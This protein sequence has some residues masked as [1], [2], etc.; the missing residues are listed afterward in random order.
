MH[1][2][3]CKMH[4]KMQTNIVKTYKVGYKIKNSLTTQWLIYIIKT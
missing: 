1:K 3:M 4:N 2:H